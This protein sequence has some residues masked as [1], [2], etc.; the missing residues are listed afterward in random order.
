MIRTSFL[1][2]VEPYLGRR[3]VRYQGIDRTFTYGQGP[4][5]YDVR[6]EFDKD[7]KVEKKILWPGDFIL[8]STIERFTMP[9]DVIGVVHDKSS[10]IRRGIS[11]HNTVIEPGWSGYLTLEIANHSNEHVEIVHGMPI[12]QIILHELDNPGHYDGKYQNQERGPVKPR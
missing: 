8:A 7:G 10:W 1:G 9:D 5:G 12:A 3:T 2:I 11:V 6:V 4:A